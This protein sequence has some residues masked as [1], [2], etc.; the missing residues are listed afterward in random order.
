MNRATSSVPGSRAGA[1]GGAPGQPKEDE[2]HPCLTAH[3]RPS[4]VP[5]RMLRLAQ[6]LDATGLGKTKIYE[7]QSKGEFPMRVKITSHTVGWVEEEVQA[8]LICRIGMNCV[9][10]PG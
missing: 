10:P 7:L 3:R 9:S 1:L 6:V 5:I 4:S 8:W 2:V